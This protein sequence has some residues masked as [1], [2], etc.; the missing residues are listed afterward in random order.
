MDTKQQ[1][2]DLKIRTDPPVVREVVRR[3][4]RG[5]SLYSLY[6]AKPPVLAQS[7]AV[8]LKKKYNNGQ[9]EFV[10]QEIEAS[11]MIDRIYP[12]V[13]ESHDERIGR[14]KVRVEEDTQEVAEALKTLPPLGFDDSDG[15]GIHR[16]NVMYGLPNI[17]WSI[18][19]LEAA[20]IPKDKA[21]A[22]LSEYD[23]LHLKR[24][25]AAVTENDGENQ[26]SW[27]RDFR[28][29]DR[30]VALHYLVRFTTEYQDGPFDVL[31]RAAILIA[32]GLL[33]L[34]NRIRNA[35][36]NLVRYE[37][38]RESEYLEA[39]L[40][41]TKKYYVTKKQR[42]RL[43]AEVKALFDDTNSEEND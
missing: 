30:Y 42:D 11:E 28:G 31:N 23:D 9:L 32:K 39:Y 12:F 19:G 20:N 14:V 38:W 43:D 27:L 3:L 16:M 37:V 22:L 15:L 26:K 33:E 8:A 18:R 6:N 21:L 1:L 10:L 24:V 5:Q 13:G 7:T 40:E 2:L 25:S 41:S 4:S 36:E 34:D 29:L 35:G 17:S